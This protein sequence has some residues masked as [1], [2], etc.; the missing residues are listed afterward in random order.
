MTR[1]GR[2][3]RQGLALV[4][5]SS[6]L[7]PAVF[8]GCAAAREAPADL[9]LHGGTVIDG[10]GAPPVRADVAIRGERI[11]AVTP[12]CDHGGARVIDV[13]GGFVLPGF[14]DMHA[15]LLEHGRGE[16]GSIP[17]RVDWELVRLHLRLLVRHGV[18]TVRDPGSET[19]TA[20]TLRRMLEERTVE[21]PRLRTA[22]RILNASPFDPEPFQPVRNAEEL[23]REIRW[24]RAA[25]VDLVKIYSSM[26]PELT[27]VA[28]EEAHALGLP[29]VGHLGRTSWAEA[30]RL[31][32][33]QIA[34]GASWSPGELPPAAREDY[35]QDMFGRVYW[36][37]HLDLEGPEVTR[38]L[39]E[40]VR[41][42]VVVD[43]TLIAYHTKFFG[44]DPRWLDNPDNRL[45]PA[46]SIAGWRA[47]AFTRGWTEEQFAAAQAAWP[48][49]LAWVRLMHERG[50]RL[51][52]GTDMPTPWIVPGAS[53]HE[54]LSLLRDAGIPEAAILRMATSEGAAALGL[55]GDVGIVRAG[56]RAD[57]VV[58]ERDPLADI[59]HTR[60]VS[61]VFQAGRATEPRRYP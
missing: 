35:V 26:P 23:R 55:A 56:L 58:L 2:S 3:G 30:A 16:D 12:A 31:G 40:L 5:V 41:H 24:Q 6:V 46:R 53:F 42:R 60:S 57:L 28:V 39:D 50:V 54:E 25:G 32:I 17:P 14:V 1:T 18:T 9:V 27:R 15:H 48:K 52:V 10:T 20:V 38:T 51:V 36:L 43:P 59:R 61:M 29:V 34:H 13:S 7:A 22:G 33:D 8:S 37:R 49:M 21:G 47:G 19:E 45:L 11:A 4:F 44:D